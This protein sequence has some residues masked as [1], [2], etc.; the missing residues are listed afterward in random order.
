MEARLLFLAIN[1]AELDGHSETARGIGAPGTSGNIGI[2]GPRWGET[3]EVAV[4]V[5][6]A[7]FEDTGRSH[8][9][10]CGAVDHGESRHPVAY[11]A[12]NVVVV[13]GSRSGVVDERLL[14]LSR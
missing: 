11:A 1:D 13:A 9:A 12:P 5:A 4:V 2:V 3:E 10:D 6:A 7:A 14:L 8:N